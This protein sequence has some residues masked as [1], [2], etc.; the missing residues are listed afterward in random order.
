MWLVVFS[1]SRLRAVR[2][3]CAAPAS[4][5]LCPCRLPVSRVGGVRPVVTGGWKMEL[6]LDKELG[7]STLRPRLAASRSNLLL[8][9]SRKLEARRRPRG[10]STLPDLGVVKPSVSGRGLAGDVLVPCST[11][12]G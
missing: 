2:W 1:S 3:C 4:A 11:G 8:V 10:L 12:P 7:L 5:P 6:A 9:V